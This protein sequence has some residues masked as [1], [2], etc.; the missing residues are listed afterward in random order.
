[1]SQIAPVVLVAVV[2]RVLTAQILATMMLLQAV[3]VYLL[4]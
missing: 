2:A 1:M 4:L 3:R